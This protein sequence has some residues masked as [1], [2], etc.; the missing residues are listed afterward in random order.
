MAGYHESLKQK[1][2]LL[3]AQDL[4][5]RMLSQIVSDSLPTELRELWGSAASYQMMKLL[6]YLPYCSPPG[7]IGQPFSFQALQFITKIQYPAPVEFL[8]EQQVLIRWY[9]PLQAGENHWY[10]LTAGMSEKL[11]GISNSKN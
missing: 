6:L 10:Q 5:Y 4:N 9:N 7:E 1:I 8:I 3:E 2:L 11:M